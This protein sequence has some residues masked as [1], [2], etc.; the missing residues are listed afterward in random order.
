MINHIIK[1]R[2][3]TSIVATILLSGCVTTTN[4]ANTMAAD[5]WQLTG[6]I[7]IA[8]ADSRCSRERCPSRSDQG[9]ITWKQQAN[10]YHITLNDPFGR[11]LITLNGND[12][13]LHAQSPGKAPIIAEPQQFIALMVADSEQQSILNTLTPK[14][15]R[16]WVT[17]RHR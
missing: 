3:L 5:S 16:H 17:G 13:S 8:Y 9:K 10:D 14:L 2:A 1:H 4:M 6:K 12:K 11:L 7:A 15:L